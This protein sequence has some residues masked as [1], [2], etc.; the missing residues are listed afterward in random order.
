MTKNNQDVYQQIIDGIVSLQDNENRNFN[1]IEYRLQ[2]L[3]NQNNTI[4]K[5]LID[6]V[7]ELEK[8]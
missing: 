4:K 3:E 1:E 5:H 6:M 2:E 7:S 8:F